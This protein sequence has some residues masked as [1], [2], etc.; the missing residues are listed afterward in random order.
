MSVEKK[1][2][3]LRSVDDAARRL[4]RSLVRT[5]RS[6]SLGTIDVADGSPSVSRISLSTAIDGEPTFLIST[7]S[8]HTGNLRADP[9][10]SIL[11]G[12]P[13]S[14]DPLSHP[15]MTIIG[16]ADEVT[17][18]Y[19]DECRSRFLRRHPEAKLYADFPDFSF[20]KVRV[21]RASLN[22]GFGRAYALAAEDVIP[23]FECASDLALTEERAVNHMNEDHRDAI[24]HY[25]KMVGGEGTGWRLATLDPEGIDLVRDDTVARVWFEKPLA[26]ASELRPVLVELARRGVS[27]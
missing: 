14:G 19:R 11:V 5:A 10:C 24:D 6:A 15:R 7:L 3:A 2:D 8:G 27:P 23:T 4:A 26:S 9:K 13:G 16:T 1:Q 12:E 18:S 20:W 17:G 21:G 22:A 25:A